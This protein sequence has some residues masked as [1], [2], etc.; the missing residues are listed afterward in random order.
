MYEMVRYVIIWIYLALAHY[1]TSGTTDFCNWTGSSFTEEKVH[2]LVLQVRL[3]CATGQI[4]WF[5]PGQALRVVL[6]PGLPYASRTALCIKPSPSLRGVNVF[7][8]RFGRLKLLTTERPSRETIRCFRP[9][10]AH[11]PVIYLEASVQSDNVPW[12]RRA[13]GFKY[14]LLTNP[15]TGA[16]PDHTGLEAPCRP[17][18]NTEL[19]MAICISDFVV[20]GSIQNISH[21]SDRETSS[22]QVSATRVFRQHSSVFVQKSAPYLTPLPPPSWS[23]HITT[24]LRCHMKPGDGEFLFTG[25]EHFGRAWLG[26]AP[27]FKD[28]LSV[29]HSARAA[30]SNPCHFPLD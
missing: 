3:R 15:R 1:L 22:I 13:V 2:R 25:S 4:R 10:E 9:D 26:C 7:T 18:N 23:G 30:R 29:Y 28:F 24:L 17:C 16:G 6:E 11:A 19:L 14:E 8:E 21:N 12:R 27:R 5:S 20:Q